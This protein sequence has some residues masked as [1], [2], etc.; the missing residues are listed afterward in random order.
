MKRINNE[1]ILDTIYD[2]AD[3]LGVRIDRFLELIEEEFGEQPIDVTNL[4]EEVANE[5]TA[6]R[7]SKR[8]Q[9]RLARAAEDESAMQEDI[10]LFK[11]RFPEV[12]AEDIPDSVWEEVQNGVSLSHAYA[13]YESTSRRLNEQAD[14]VNERNGLASASAVKG[15]ATEPVYTKEQVE[16]MSGK[17]VLSNY[18]SILKAMKG[19]HF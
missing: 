12:T 11:S 10:R 19:W 1:L 4:P 2:L 9:K 14:R 16:K 17:D 18:K 13:L 5:L 8:E 6:A 15:G 7:E 3:S